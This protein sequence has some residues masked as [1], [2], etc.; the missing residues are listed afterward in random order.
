MTWARADER[1]GCDDRDEADSE[2]APGHP[3]GLPAEPPFSFLGTGGNVESGEREA[4]PDV[5]KE[6]SGRQVV[7]DSGDQLVE[8]TALQRPPSRQHLGAVARAG[9]REAG[10]VPGVV[11]LL[12]VSG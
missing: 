5:R 3:Q 11:D 10:V 1:E 6:A 7:V 2:R 12:A 8:L 9:R 4:V